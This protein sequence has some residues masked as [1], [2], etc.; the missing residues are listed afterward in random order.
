MTGNV[1]NLG[2]YVV[3][4]EITG[5]QKLIQIKDSS[6]NFYLGKYSIKGSDIIGK[7]YYSTLSLEDGKWVIGSILNSEEILKDILSIDANAENN[8][9]DEEKSIN[10]MQELK[11]KRT[12]Y[13]QLLGREVE[14]DS[15]DSNSEKESG[16]EQDKLEKVKR[17]RNEI[18]SLNKA[19]DSNLIRSL[20]LS[21]SSFKNKTNF[22]KE[23][24]IKKLQ[25][26]YLK[27]IILLPSTLLNIIETSSCQPKIRSD[28][29]SPNSVG[30]RWG[31]CTV[32]IETIGNILTHGNVSSG[33]KVLLY[34]NL[35]NGVVGGSIYRQLCNIGSLYEISMNK[36]TFDT[37]EGYFH[38]KL[39]INFEA[40]VN[41]QKP[42]VHYH[43][44]PMSALEIFYKEMEKLPDEFYDENQGFL[45]EKLDIKHEW[46]N[47]KIN[48]HSK[49]DLN[50][51]KS[52]NKKKRVY[53]RINML[54]NLYSEGVDTVILVID[55]VKWQTTVNLQNNRK[56]NSIE[57]TKND[58]N[59]INNNHSNHIQDDNSESNRIIDEKTI[60]FDIE[61]MIQ[62]TQEYLKPGG[63]LLIFT[64]F[65]TTELLQI[66]Q[67]LSLSTRVDNSKFHPF[68]GIKLEETFIREHQIIDQRTHP[69]MDANLPIFSGFL[70]SAIHIS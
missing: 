58:S 57:N 19:N 6:Q 47:Y 8:Q 32:R 22:S 36:L 10:N 44:I 1:I 30:P 7:N 43:T 12:R 59:D 31:Q 38:G 11:K 42:K 24:Y 62:V 15:D 9:V 70:L 2:D 33:S 66:H 13:N 56:Q 68:I 54:E 46:L 45:T 51:E 29:L 27:Q 52:Q 4:R 63:K 25:L 3:I 50:D 5:S 48:T 65:M 49:G 23:K 67:D 69:T 34:D 18:L 16:D 61:K 40:I 20:A 21:S 53:N 26:R 60:Y 39:A 37:F 41:D 55:Q 35:S 14:V 17:K 64:P 28:K